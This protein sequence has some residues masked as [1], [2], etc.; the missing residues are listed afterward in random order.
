MLIMT[1]KTSTRSSHSAH[2]ACTRVGCDRTA[3]EPLQCQFFGC[4]NPGDV[5]KLDDETSW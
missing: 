4:Y 2:F 5:I 1:D 3:C